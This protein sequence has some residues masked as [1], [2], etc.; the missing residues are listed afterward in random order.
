[1]GLP[2]S[3]PS[4][5][6]S[7]SAYSELVECKC[8]FNMSPLKAPTPLNPPQTSNKPKS[9]LEEEEVSFIQTMKKPR[10][11]DS[12]S[13]AAVSEEDYNLSQ[14]RSMGEA[15]ENPEVANFC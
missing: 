4:R 3:L 2:I 8:K 7:P 1:M 10:R 11:M 12:D 5:G 13:L 15:V 9:R 14:T 6:I